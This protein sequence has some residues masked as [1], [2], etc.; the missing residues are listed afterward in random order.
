MTG[1]PLKPAPARDRAPYPK[2][3]VVSVVLLTN[4]PKMVFDF[5]G[6]T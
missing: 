1:R 6:M 4:N 2:G 3:E 5:S